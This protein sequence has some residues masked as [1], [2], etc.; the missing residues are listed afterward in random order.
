M[1]GGPFLVGE[2][3]MSP[4]NNEHPMASSTNLAYGYTPTMSHNSS[5]S[6]PLP[7]RNRP[8]PSE[9]AGF[10]PLM[11]GPRGSPFAPTLRSGLPNRQL[12][13]LFPS[14]PAPGGSQSL[15]MPMKSP[16][17]SDPSYHQ[18]QQQSGIATLLRAGEHL[19]AGA[20]MSPPTRDDQGP[21]G[22]ASAPK[23]SRPP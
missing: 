22:I 1:P 19:A 18:Q 7:D 15:P 14:R 11:G 20:R 2:H 6:P 4:R 3:S 8:S 12:P 10:P 21:D 13:P 23:E 5:Q 17:T 16:Q 9:P